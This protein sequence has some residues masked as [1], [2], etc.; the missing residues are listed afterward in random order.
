M[1]LPSPPPP[2]PASAPLWG[3]APL[4]A[5]S[6]HA[7][8]TATDATLHPKRTQN[9]LHV[10][11]SLAKRPLFMDHICLFWF[12][13]PIAGPT[14]GQ[15]NP[16]RLKVVHAPQDPV[17]GLGWAEEGVPRSSTSLVALVPTGAIGRQ[18]KC[19]FRTC[20]DRSFATA[21]EW[22]PGLARASLRPAQSRKRGAQA[23]RYR[24]GPW[25]TL[26]TGTLGDRS[27]RKRR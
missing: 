20:P 13:A 5:E 3:A 6:A 26:W 19:S 15:A 16:E 14:R 1:P 22:E 2:S 27:D 4:D 23:R 18:R 10:V 12:R 24:P 17:F 9:R 7:L 21:L 25:M 8:S 11:A